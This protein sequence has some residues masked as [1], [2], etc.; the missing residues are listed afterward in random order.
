MAQKH[1]EHSDRIYLNDLIRKK[2]TDWSKGIKILDDVSDIPDDV[3]SIK[4]LTEKM[5][6]FYDAFIFLFYGYEYIDLDSQLQATRLASLSL[7]IKLLQNKTSFEN[8]FSN[9]D[10]SFEKAL[11]LLTN[12]TRIKNQD[13]SNLFFYPSIFLLEN[14]FKYVDIK[15]EKREIKEIKSAFSTMPSSFSRDYKT[16]FRNINKKKKR[17]RN[18]FLNS[19]SSAFKKEPPFTF[20]KNSSFIQCVTYEEKMAVDFLRF[21]IGEQGQIVPISTMGNGMTDPNIKE[22]T[23]E[24]LEEINNYFNN[25]ETISF[26][27]ETIDYLNN[28]SIPTEVSMKAYVLMLERLMKKHDYYNSLPLVYLICKLGRE[29]K[30]N[31]TIKLLFGQKIHPLLKRRKVYFPILRLFYDNNVFLDDVLVNKI[32]NH[33]EKTYKDL[34]RN[35][36][37]GYLREILSN[38]ELLRVITRM[39]YSKIRNA[40]YRQIETSANGVEIADYYLLFANFLCSKN[41]S[42]LVKDIDKEKLRL[43]LDWQKRGYDNSQKG[44][45]EIKGDPINFSQQYIDDINS[46]ILNDSRN[47]GYI[48]FSHSNSDFIR[49]LKRGSENPL[50]KLTNT[51]VILK[52]YPIKSGFNL[53]EDFCNLIVQAMEESIIG[54]EYKLLNKFEYRQYIDD[55]YSEI[56]IDYQ[57]VIALFKKEKELYEVIKEKNPSANLS[58]WTDDASYSDV[59]QLFPLLETLII[60]NGIKNNIPYLKDDR[61]SFG[62]RKEPATILLRRFKKALN[63]FKS[64]YCVS[65][66][67]AVY[68]LMYDSNFM[69]I[70]NNVIHGND[71][72]IDKATLSIYR[73][74]V[75]ISISIIMKRNETE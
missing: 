70:R 65:D 51:I 33:A 36:R 9:C 72:P 20:N 57:M 8:A 53:N 43:Q 23:S 7:A 27:T 75:L 37:P 67:I 32:S 31:K 68:H 30:I 64:L 48:C 47:F 49:L 18:S 73:K 24:H 42:S 38:K 55:Y 66:L 69:N 63:D 50:G 52:D 16:L 14:V 35:K 4:S 19:F 34:I 59:T 40:F 39:R 60:L 1:L 45:M 11:V 71:Y 12:I 29:K 74:I 56:S 44:M 13:G 41:I 25:D 3:D 58:D 46:S 28:N 17:K 21:S 62:K 22:W 15:W 6:D 5:S 10:N 26:L 54:Q 61:G 2:E